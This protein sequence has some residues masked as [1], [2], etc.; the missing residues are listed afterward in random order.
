M[1]RVKNDKIGTGQDYKG[2]GNFE[3]FMAE[4]LFSGK[5]TRHQ[6]H[7]WPDPKH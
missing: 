3:I 5:L 7:S 2:R 6:H 1:G 4:E